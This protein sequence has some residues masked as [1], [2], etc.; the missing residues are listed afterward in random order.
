[1]KK[2]L[3][4]LICLFNINIVYAVELKYEEMDFYVKLIEPLCEYFVPIKK[5]YVEDTLELL[6]NLEPVHYDVEYSYKKLDNINDFGKYKNE[7][8]LFNKIV[9]SI[10][11]NDK[12]DLN[13][14]FTQ[15]LIWDLIGNFDVIITDKNG[16][17]IKEYNDLYQTYLKKVND[18]ILSGKIDSTTNNETYNI[19]LWDKANIPYKSA[20]IVYDKE[21]T[22]GL[23]ITLE[24]DNININAINVGNYQLNKISQKENYVYKNNLSYYWYFNGDLVNSNINVLVKGINLKIKENL[25]GINNRFGDALVSDMSYELFYNNELKLNINDLNNN[26]VRENSSYILKDKSNNVGF[27]NIND[28]NFEVLDKDYVLEINKNVISKNINVNI[29]DNNTYYIYLK[30]NNELYETIDKN[31]NLIT[32]PY[33]IYYINSSECDYLKELVINNNEEEVLVINNL[34]K[35]NIEDKKEVSNKLNINEFNEEE[36]ILE[37]I[38]KEEI[39]DNIE[40]IPNPKTGD[41][42]NLYVGLFLINIL[43]IFITRIILRKT[44]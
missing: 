12:T 18:F 23:N 2:I 21:D 13:Y 31:A 15:I 14:A 27:D 40:S 19:D 39:R 25:I 38:K 9:Y 32:L 22:K 5:V 35:E 17:S 33:G 6:F 43:I 3:F 44:N 8:D 34:I 11:S 20:N 26:Y 37:N 24:K 42:I 10:Y 16:I 36:I 29:K 4:I 1:M 28:I 7:I 30:S 41:N